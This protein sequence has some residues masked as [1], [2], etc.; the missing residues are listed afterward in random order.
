MLLREDFEKKELSGL[1]P[2]AVFSSKTAGRKFK[3][4]ECPTR[5][6]FQRDRDRIIHS[7][8]FRRLEYKTQVF[9]NHEGDYYR[10]RLTHT[11]EVA[12]ISRNF[13][14]T[15]KLN[16]DLA[17]AIALAHDL[18]HTPFG[19][20]GEEAMD[21]L[22]KDHGG[23]EHNQQS[24]RVVTRLEHRYPDF[25]GLNLTYE[26]LEGIAKHVGE[27]DKPNIED[28]KE[29]G[30]PILE[31]QIVNFADE[32]AYLTHD[33]DDGLTSGLLR[34]PQLEE[35]GVLKRMKEEIAK[36]Y[37][38]I[39]DRLI[40]Y[41]L[42]RRLINLFVTDMQAETKK[43]LARQKL[44]SL[45]G[46]RKRGNNIVG[47]SPSIK[48]DISELRK[49]LFDNLYR[50]PKVK[51]MS[52]TAKVIVEDLFKTYK[53]DPELLPKPYQIKNPEKT[54]LERNICDYIA[55]MTDRFALKEHQ[56]LCE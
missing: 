2:Y 55:G 21:K 25:D 41:Q 50:H 36:D 49:F 52:D 40:K 23:F 22:M 15:F 10:T 46:V 33:V 39:P 9:V 4:P 11:L 51:T 6:A 13:A 16:E 32:I 47:F 19:H 28:F 24:Y 56:R 37:P 1:A 7:S 34:L 48:S 43:R 31:V 3:E 44:E 26:V 30:Y 35:V 42:I 18:G 27:Y 45:D 5:T 14:R 54:N 12:Q 20:S 8:A 29:S 53:N 38:N 17:E